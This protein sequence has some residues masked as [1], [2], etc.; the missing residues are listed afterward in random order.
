MP[1]AAGAGRNGS[2]RMGRHRIVR[3]G[4]R[5]GCGAER[6]DLP[7]AALTR[8]RHQLR[9]VAEQAALLVPRQPFRGA[10]Q[11]DARPGS[12]PARNTVSRG[13]T[14]IPWNSASSATPS[15]ISIAAPLS[16]FP[17]ASQGWRRYCQSLLFPLPRYLRYNA[18]RLHRRWLLSIAGSGRQQRSKL[19]AERVR[20]RLSDRVAAD[21]VPHHTCLEIVADRVAEAELQILAVGDRTNTDAEIGSE[22][23]RSRPLFA[24]YAKP[25]V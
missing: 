25:A 4:H 9:A 19:Q 16:P 21:V 17:K 13:I 1:P 5:A 8:F 10:T 22:Q 2:H 18:P 6:A 23:A 12:E 14:G 15:I 11:R 7:A 3:L 20:A 24:G